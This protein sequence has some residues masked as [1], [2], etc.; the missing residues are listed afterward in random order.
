MIIRN[1]L[2]SVILTEKM[3]PVQTSVKG[4]FT[5]Q[6]LLNFFSSGKY[7]RF[8]YFTPRNM[9]LDA[10]FGFL[11]AAVVQMRFEE[12]LLTLWALTDLYVNG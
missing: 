3:T 1:I 8:C 4:I 5:F 12:Q 6:L 2:R 11:W 7:T 10:I 9:K